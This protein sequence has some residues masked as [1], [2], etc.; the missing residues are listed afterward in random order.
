MRTVSMFFSAALVLVLAGS[1]AAQHIE[2]QAVKLTNGTTYHGRVT[3]SGDSLSIALASG[4]TLTLARAQVRSV[5]TVRGQM[6]D[7]D[8]WAQDLNETRLFFAP[9]ARTLPRGAGYVST[10]MIVLPFVGYGVT[11]AITLS[12]G[13]L[14]FLG[15]GAP[16]VGYAAPKVRV[17]ATETMQAAVGALA[18][19]SSDADE[20]VG[21]LYAVTSLGR[22][23]DASVSL[24]AG[25]GYVGSEMANTPVLM[26]GFESRTS[27]R[28]KLVSEN[29]IFPGDGVILSI[30]PRFMGDRMSGDL[31]LAMPLFGDGTFIFPLVNFVWNW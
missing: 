6:R 12:G 28:T 22:S 16:V 15:G 11:D 21:I 4:G 5:T 1:T 8:F 23:S 10:Y 7:G 9:T 13:V 17:L 14:P 20:S 29:W 2:V 30:G 25:F 26:G 27:R 3:E 24:G 31:G 19:F 18:F